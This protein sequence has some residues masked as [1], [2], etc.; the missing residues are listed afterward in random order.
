MITQIVLDRRGLDQD[1]GHTIG[2]T[3]SQVLSKLADQDKLQTALEEAKEAKLVAEKALHEKQEL[4][5]E[6]TGQGGKPYAHTYIVSEGIF[7][8]FILLLK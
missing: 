6:Y 4:Q 8:L 1:L 2:I 5:K 3:V 7:I